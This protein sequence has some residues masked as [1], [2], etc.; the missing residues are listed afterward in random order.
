ML[1]MKR[2]V[3]MKYNLKHDTQVRVR[4][5]ETDQ[6]GYCYYGNYAL[7]LE[8]GRVEA[9]RQL[10][11]S[12]RDLE[13]KGI[14]LPVANLEIR[15]VKPALYDDLLTVSTRITEVAGA[16]LYFE[17]DIHK[18]DGSLLITASTLLIFVDKSTMRPT[19]PPVEF[20]ELLSPF[21]INE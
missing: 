7:Y 5:G 15:Y 8:V 6:M 10:G 17:Y 12:Y 14:M 19:K 4:Y 20:V 9:M 21:E 2:M 1:E 11:M 3:E 16:K 13:E 18:E